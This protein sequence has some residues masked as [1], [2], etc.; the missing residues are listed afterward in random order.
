MFLVV[1]IS[2]SE[3]YASCP[4]TMTAEFYLFCSQNENLCL[5]NYGACQGS[6]GRRTA[7]GKLTGKLRK[8]TE[9]V[10][11][12]TLYGQKLVLSYRKHYDSKFKIM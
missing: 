4:N 7:P 3:I 5:K 9:F 8:R 1:E 11:P 2:V 12:N 6:H 10:W